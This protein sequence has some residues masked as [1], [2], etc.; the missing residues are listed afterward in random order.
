[1]TGFREMGFVLY[2][3]WVTFTTDA[4][5]K[6]STNW[7]LQSVYFSRGKI[8]NMYKSI[9]TPGVYYM[10][11]ISLY[12]TAANNCCMCIQPLNSSFM[13]YPCTLKKI[14][15]SCS[16]RVPGN[17]IYIFS[18]PQEGKVMC[19]THFLYWWPIAMQRWAVARKLKL[20]LV[21]VQ[22]V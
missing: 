13:L 7:A 18:M 3:L 10:Y 6:T 9:T 8:P 12:T 5:E 2:S 1:M 14:T 21:L 19:R 17:C 16:D 20:N 11:N 15:C 4:R 22:L